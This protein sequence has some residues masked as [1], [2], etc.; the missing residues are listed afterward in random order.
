MKALFT[1]FLTVS[2]STSLMIGIVLLLRLLFK[3]APKAL[4]CG[5]WALVILRLLLPFQ[6]PLEFSLR[7][8]TPVFTQASTAVVDQQQVY[9]QTEIPPFVPVQEQGSF[10]PYCR[11]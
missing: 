2:I 6:I 4:I 9:E 1:G 11:Y 5:V 7:P 8:K 10:F 3:K